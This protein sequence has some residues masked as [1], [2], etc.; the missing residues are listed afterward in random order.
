MPE[1]NTDSPRAGTL[2]LVATPIGTAGD[3][4]PRARDVLAEADLVLAEDTRRLRSL[5]S[6][7]DLT[8]GAKILSFNEHNEDKRL[9]A[10]LERLAAGGSVALV[11][12]AG[13]PVLSDP[14]FPLVRAAR[15]EGYAV[16]SVPGP[17]SFVAALAAS[18]QPPL[19]ATL[20]GFLPPRKAARRRALEAL[21]AAPGTVVVLISP[22]RIGQELADAAEVLGGERPATLL[23][24]IRK[25]HERA[26][27]A[28]LAELAGHPESENPRGEYILVVGPAE[29]EVA[30]ATPEE[31]R[32]LYDD[33]IA[34]GLGRPDALRRTARRLS[35]SRRAVYDLLEQSP[36]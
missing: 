17:S 27:M 4:S 3:L 30:D 15:S 12:D 11:S 1:G 14:G 36:D 29:E 24:E 26:V 9:P 16:L 13:T 2:W 5:L 23:A 7:L 8:T 22:H 34:E 35:L 19:P 10:V 6:R 21:K 31:V 20:A 28:T 25:L 18:G 32:R 33:A